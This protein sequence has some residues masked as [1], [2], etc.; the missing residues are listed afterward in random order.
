MNN[1]PSRPGPVYDRMMRLLAQNDLPALCD[2]LGVPLEGAP[3]FLSGTFPRETLATD[4]LVRVGP[5]RMLHTEYILRP[6]ADVAGRITVYRG[7]IMQRH[8][9][10]RLTQVAL[11]LGEGTLRPGDDPKNGFY[12]G[13]RTLYLREADPAA[14]LAHPGLAPLA[15]LARGD[16]RQRG[17][18][19]AEAFELI[20]REPEHRRNVLTEATMTLAMITLDRPTIDRIRKEIDMTVADMADFYAESDFAV[21]IRDRGRAQGRQEGRREGSERVLLALL[22]SRFGPRPELPG[23]ADLLARTDDDDAAIMAI[24]AAATPE[25]IEIPAVRSESAGQ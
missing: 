5:E 3:E 19:L 21:L 2:W 7:H 9:G 18:R 1:D 15:V 6:T 10:A 11:V 23:I 20:A 17:E 13:L 25:E 24:Q 8:P 22:R 12:L 14:L 16:R 4:L